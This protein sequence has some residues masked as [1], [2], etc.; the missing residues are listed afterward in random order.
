MSFDRTSSGGPP[1][2]WAARLRRVLFDLRTEG[3]GAGRDALAAGVGILIGCSPFYGFHLLLCWLVGSLFG[4]NRLKIYLAANISNPLMAPLLV[5]SEL[6]AGAWLRR[7][8]FHELSL[9]TART[10]NPWTF[11]LDIL[12]GSLA[13]GG[14]LGLIVAAVTYCAVQGAPGDECFET[15]VRQS[16][17]RYVN[18]SMTAWE[19]ARV[20]LRW[21]PVYRTT[22]CAGLLPSGGTLLDIGCG[23]GLTLALL[24]DARRTFER[25]AWPA[26][27]APPPTFDRLVGVEIRPRVA[28]LARRALGADAEI[29]EADASSL[30]AIRC[31]A[32]LIFD[33][34]HLMRPEQQE[35]MLETLLS[36]LVCGGMIFVREADAAAGWSFYT[37]SAVNR[38]KAVITG[39]WHQ[40]FHFR[41]TADWAAFFERLG[42]SVATRHQGQGTPFANFLFVLSV[43]QP[44]SAANHPPAQSA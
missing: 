8:S 1:A 9:E 27:C 35:A 10:I 24:A 30:S 34:L 28:D 13:I 20:K 5:F 33:V 4:L 37:V 39:R 25:G 12:V 29:L 31:R 7:G 26:H 3:G 23:Q 21:D 14:G 17:D 38:L 43:R 15:I 44:A 36:A 6:Q 18:A 42:F 40:P 22:L 16:P 41:T 32:V 2:S 11:G 19:F